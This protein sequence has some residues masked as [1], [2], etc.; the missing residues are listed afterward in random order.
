MKKTSL[1]V[2]GAILAVT[3]CSLVHAQSMDEK[4]QAYEQY[5]RSKKASG[6]ESVE[7]YTSPE[8]Y[9]STIADQGGMVATEPAASGGA[10]VTSSS[11]TD[12]WG[13]LQPF[14]YDMFTER[15][16]NFAPPEIATVP[17]DYEIGPGDNLLVSIW[18]RVDLELSLT[19]NR[20]GRVFIPKVGEVVCYGLTLDGL[21]GRLEKKLSAFYSEFNMSVSLGKIRT[22]KVY[23][24]GEVKQPGGYTLSSLSTLF[25]A[26]YTAQGPNARGSMRKVRLLRGGK[27]YKEID[28]YSFLLS[29]DASGDVKLHSEDVVFVP[30]AGERVNVYGEVNRPAVYELHGGETIAQVVELAGGLAPSAYTRRIQLDRL[31][32]NDSRV[33]HDIDLREESGSDG[34]MTARGG[35][36]IM[37]FSMNKLRENVVWLEGRVKHPGAFQIEER[38]NIA[39]LLFNGEQLFD[40]VYMQRADLIRTHSDGKQE[41]IPVNLEAIMAQKEGADIKLLAKDSL[42][43]YSTPQVSRD[44]YVSIRG[45]VKMP[46][47]Y[48]IFKD[49]KLSDLIF[50]AG[51]LNR[52]AFMLSAEIARLDSEGTTELFEINLKK[53][54]DEKDGSYDVV[55]EEDDQVFV[56]TIPDW[57]IEKLV[58]VEGEVKFPGQYSL[59]SNDMTLYEIIQRAG[60]LTS[61]AFPT[62]AVFTRPEIAAELEQ[63][64]LSDIITKSAP[65]KE[66]SLGRV[67][68]ETVF[69]VDTDRMS[70]IVIDLDLLI[71]DND[72][73]KQLPL[74]HGDHIFIPKNPSGVQ[75]MGAVASNG[76]LQFAP[77][78]KIS[79]YIENAGGYL[80][81][82]DKDNVRLVK[83][84]G[85]VLSGKKARN[86]YVDLGDAVVV[87]T[88]IK[89]NRDWWNIFTSSAT[90]LGGLATTLYIID[91]F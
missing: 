28:L 87:P 37:V 74:R 30:L 78:L 20:E 51:N 76:T 34:N 53:L 24:Y 32:S 50:R 6:T 11:P 62:G 69:D 83:A 5:M 12:I 4:K 81:N 23:V 19:V 58:T 65:L 54:I 60:G 73:G 45:D 48:K 66:D 71:N 57:Q 40:D 63:K 14:G 31:G 82:S 44:K 39:S 38:P 85:R 61:E 41:I 52:S 46:G 47:K 42:V 15:S 3:F 13:D 79:D 80:K 59:T 21:H 70:R 7:S 33:I 22:I 17:P 36:Q 64:Q 89:K 16:A 68:P 55:L 56:R 77:G 26:L 9:E 91:K 8:I 84:D 67:Y 25:N 1:C 43:V 29:G 88:E 27:T 86:R 90:I 10:Q 72:R 2:L 35:D 49:M 75:I 18:G